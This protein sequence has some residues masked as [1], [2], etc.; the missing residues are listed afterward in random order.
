[1]PW[2]ARFWRTPLRALWLV[3]SWVVLVRFYL[4]R[5]GLLFPALLLALLLGW[6][7]TKRLVRL[8]WPVARSFRSR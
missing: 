5:P 7:R 3:R 6:H 8:S 1:M 4:A 2:L